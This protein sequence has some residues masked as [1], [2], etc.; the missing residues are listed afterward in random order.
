MGEQAVQGATSP[1][2]IRE[3]QRAMLLDLDALD[4]MLAEERFE[5][6]VT[7]YGVEQEM[8][9]VDEDAC[10][11]PVGPEVLVQST[12]PRLT[13]ELARFNLEANLPPGLLASG[14]L[15]ELRGELESVLSSVR[16]LAAG[17]SARPLFTGILPTLHGSDIG[18]HNMTPSARYD[19]LNANILAQRGGEIVV[20]IRGLDELHRRQPDVMLEAANASIQL[21]IQVDPDGF[22]DAYNRAQLISAPLLAVSANSPLIMG[23]RLWHE[24]RIALFEL[25]TDV[26]SDAELARGKRPRVGFGEGWVK[27]SVIELFRADVMSYAVLLTRELGPRP[28]SELEAGRMP[29]L[30][31]LTLH[32]GTVWRWNRACYGVAD[33]V[34]HLRIENRVLPSGPTIADEV[35]NAALFY[36]L[37]SAPETHFAD[38]KDM[39]F[40]RVKESFISASRYGI[41]APLTWVDGRVG[42]ARE[43]V[44]RVLLPIAREGLREIG[45]S[46]SDVA[47]AL[48]PIEERVDRGVNG[49]TWI[50]R[51]YESL[52][53]RGTPEWAT[54]RLTDGLLVGQESGKPVH[55]WVPLEASRL[56]PVELD[57]RHVMRARM[58]T[59]SPDDPVE[60]ADRIFA[61]EGISHVVVEHDAELVGLVT[62]DHP[63]PGRTDVCV[64]DVMIEPTTVVPDLSLAEARA[65]LGNEPSGCLVVVS[66]GRVIGTLTEAELAKS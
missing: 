15:D 28:L 56:I 64:R 62:R 35:A 48:E 46:E 36:G 47:T 32:N 19:Q 8:F 23:R 18:L 50:L 63:A 29:A 59:V 31:A 3:F 20:F 16:E 51:A 21:H 61:W 65:A 12:D 34:P 60:L 5:T 25:A 27:E 2:E 38:L 11:A 37:M 14:F 10:A 26:R 40:A 49:A 55:E 7:R 4:R 44:G 66:D 57:V 17:Q 52:T 24:S 58:A 33:Q 1:E 54:R 22:V 45:M 30:R 9:L 42:S 39:S 43:L 13:H 53:E 41:D 6:G